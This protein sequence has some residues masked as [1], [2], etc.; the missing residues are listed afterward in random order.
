M[1]RSVILIDNLDS[2]SFNLVEAFQRLGCAVTVLRNRVEATD[3]IALA[4]AEGSLIVLSPGPGGPE[5][6]GC[7]LE[8]I[9]RAKGKLDL[10]G[11]CLGHQALVQEAGGRMCRASEPVHGKS[12]LLAH[13]R[14]GP[15]RGSPARFGSGATTR[16]AH[17]KSRPA[18]PFTRISTGWRW[19]S[20]TW[21]PARP[22]CNSI[23]SRS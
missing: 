7:C 12:N 11:V 21:P 2:F 23:P 17:V 14:A 1:S 10:L 22:G 4:E 9:E 20:A 3:V 5:S 16:S 19:R 8:L 6:A 15:L 18:S 13:D